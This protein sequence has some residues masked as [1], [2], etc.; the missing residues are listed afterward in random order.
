MMTLNLM[1]LTTKSQQ[2]PFVVWQ[3]SL[4]QSIP[5]EGEA[6]ETQEVNQFHVHEKTETQ[7]S[8]WAFPNCIKKKK[9][10]S[11]DGGGAS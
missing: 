9:K 10:D 3:F 8:Q 2:S 11:T 4:N 6:G 5:S 1:M 7:D